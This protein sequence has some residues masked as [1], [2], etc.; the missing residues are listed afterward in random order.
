MEKIE[1]SAP[2]VQPNG[3]VIFDMTRMAMLDKILA[4]ADSLQ[5]NARAA[6]FA[7]AMAICWR[8]LGQ[9]DVEMKERARSRS[10]LAGVD[11]SMLNGEKLGLINLMDYYAKK[12]LA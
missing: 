8:R 4:N 12:V 5:D 10:K 9:I 2:I 7:E 6:A 1:R 11:I 3:T